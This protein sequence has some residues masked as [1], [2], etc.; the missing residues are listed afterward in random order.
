M[1]VFMKRLI[2]GTVLALSCLSAVAFLPNATTSGN[3]GFEKLTSLAGTWKGTSPEG[4]I[5]LTYKRVSGGSAVMEIN[6]SEHHKDGMI[7]MYHLDGKDLIMTHYCSMGNQPRMRAS[8]LT[9]DGKL[10]FSFVAGTNMT[11]DD[12]HMHGLTITFK[13]N[14]HM[15][16]E[17]TLRSS[18]KDEKLPPFEMTRTH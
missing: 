2:A 10:V 8:A 13:D 16:Q 14:E 15:T 17:W 7:T 4:E 5:T 12:A 1:E 11:P 3:A 9:A 18:G 6:D